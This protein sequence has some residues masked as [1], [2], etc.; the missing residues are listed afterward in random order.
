MSSGT[1]GSC[2]IVLNIKHTKAYIMWTEEDHK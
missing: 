2:F 1:L